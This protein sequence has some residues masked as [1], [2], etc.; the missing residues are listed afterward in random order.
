MVACPA[1]TVTL[2][3]G[4]QEAWGRAELRSV[5]PAAALTTGSFPAKMGDFVG[6]VDVWSYGRLNYLLTQFKFVSLSSYRAGWTD[7][8]TF[9]VTTIAG[10]RTKQVVEYGGIGPIE[11]WAIQQAIDSIAKNIDWSQK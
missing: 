7:D 3:R 4:S 11:L 8:R 6:K 9:T 10:G 2:F 5:G 1:Y